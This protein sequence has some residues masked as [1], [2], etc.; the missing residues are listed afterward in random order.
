MIVRENDVVKLSIDKSEEYL[1]I[2]NRYILGA[3]DLAESLNCECY[4]VNSDNL[5]CASILI[6]G[7]RCRVFT[8]GEYKNR[9][10]EIFFNSKFLSD[11]LI[12][13]C[14][15]VSKCISTKKSGA[16]KMFKLE[17]LPLEILAKFC[18]CVIITRRNS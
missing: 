9:G 17:D 14:S 5:I 8:I 12:K 15:G 16:D 10:P 13:K 1:V 6:N 2:R 11:E 4:A 7:R 18:E 3:L